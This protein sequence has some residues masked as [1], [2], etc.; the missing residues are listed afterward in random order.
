MPKMKTHSA[1]KKRFKKTGNGKIKRGK[2]FRRHLL[3]KKSRK[4]KRALRHSSYVCASD[5][6]NIKKLLPYG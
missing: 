5:A 4:T 1:S 6:A 2:A 3:T